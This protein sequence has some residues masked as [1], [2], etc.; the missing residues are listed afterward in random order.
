MAVAKPTEKRAKAPAL[1]AVRFS[2]QLPGAGKVSISGDF[3]QWSAEG[4]R[5]EKAAD[6]RWTASL[7][8]APGEYQYRL[9]VDGGWQ[10]DPAA[11]KQVPNPYGSRNAV[12]TVS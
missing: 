7:N 3:T 2:T 1:K 10:D 9:L 4:I 8:L 6:G 5:L 11:A 12:L